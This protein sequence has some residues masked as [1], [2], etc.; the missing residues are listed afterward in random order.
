MCK[1]HHNRGSI[2]VPVHKTGLGKQW[3]G[4]WC[5]KHDVRSIYV[6]STCQ[7]PC[8]QSAERH[9]RHQETQNHSQVQPST[10]MKPICTISAECIP[11][12]Q[13]G[14]FCTLQGTPQIHQAVPAKNLLQPKTTT[15]Y[16]QKIQQPFW[17]LST[18]PAAHQVYLGLP[19]TT[20]PEHLVICF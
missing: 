2:S 12:P 8:I 10:P 1:L 11:Q 16:N 7:V 15:T 13:G 20:S 4:T 6:S 3:C 5:M 18:E 9:S 17:F 14:Y 19:W